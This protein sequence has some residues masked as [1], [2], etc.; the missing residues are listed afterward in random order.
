MVLMAFTSVSDNSRSTG[1][2]GYSWDVM[3]TDIRR[4]L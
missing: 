3:A 4:V 2:Y 1:V